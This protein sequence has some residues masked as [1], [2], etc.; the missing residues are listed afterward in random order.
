[1]VLLLAATFIPLG[2][3]AW[4]VITTGPRRVIELVVRP[5]VGELLLNTV[6]LVVITVP[7]CVVLGVGDGLVG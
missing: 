4:S 3:V 5:R 7:L 1:M 2:Y 6:G